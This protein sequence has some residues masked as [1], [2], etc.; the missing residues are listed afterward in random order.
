MIAVLEDGNLYQNSVWWLSIVTF[1]IQLAATIYAFVVI[2]KKPETRINFFLMS[3]TTFH[4]ITAALLIVGL[5][6]NPKMSNKINYAILSFTLMMGNWLFTIF[7]LKTALTLPILFE[8]RDSN[9]ETETEMAARQ[10][11]KAK[12]ID[13]TIGFLLLFPVIQVA[14]TYVFFDAQ[15]V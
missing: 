8:E 7:L 14:L 4:F 1:T 9:E 3:T 6:E 10:A 13:Y 12:K 2:L 15:L 5:F 11:L